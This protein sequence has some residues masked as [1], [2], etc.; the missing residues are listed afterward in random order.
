MDFLVR[1]EVSL[2]P[3]LAEAER[4]TLLRREAERGRVLRDSGTLRQIWRIPGR[5][6]NVG[7][8]SASTPDELHDALTS[9]P[10]WSYADISVTALATHPLAADTT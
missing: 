8:W 9:L 1:I 5:L 2:P 3:E 7:I 10:V 6:A 4:A